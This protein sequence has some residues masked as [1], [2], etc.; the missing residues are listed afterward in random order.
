[1]IRKTFMDKIRERL[2]DDKTQKILLITV[3]VAL[4]FAI[5]SN[6]YKLYSE[7]ENK[8]QV[9]K[10]IDDTST[11]AATEAK[12]LG[13]NVDKKLACTEGLK[14]LGLKLNKNEEDII[15]NFCIHKI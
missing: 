6:M 11:N 3:V 1:M 2:N 5:L 12:K 4:A 15:V 7:D 14:K 13:L 9:M 10:F 8:K